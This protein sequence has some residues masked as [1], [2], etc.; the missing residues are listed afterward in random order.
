MF[1]KILNQKIKFELKVQPKEYSPLNKKLPNE[2]PKPNYG[3]GIHTEAC[4]AI[5]FSWILRDWTPMDYDSVQS[6]IDDLHENLDENR[7]IIE[8]E[9]GIT[10][11]GYKY[12]YNITKMKN[13]S[14]FGVSYILNMNIKVKDKDYFINGSYDEEGMTGMRDAIG[15]ELFTRQLKEQRPNAD[16]SFEIIRNSFYCDP[17]DNDFKKGFLMNASEKE[18][19]DSLFPEHPLSQVRKYV[20]W[21]IE[22]N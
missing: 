15:M 9:N 11:N 12:I 1:K 8:V 18:S 16:V 2:I 5:I 6:V 4:H 20:Q 14:G 17:Y 21:I 3:C 10:K 22:N 7:G 13:E 19:M